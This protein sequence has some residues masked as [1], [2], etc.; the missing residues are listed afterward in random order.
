MKI[1]S[2]IWTLL[3]SFLVAFGLWLYVITVVSPESE[4]TY[5]DIPVTYQNDILEERGL[6]IVSE[7]PVKPPHTK[8]AQAVF[9]DDSN[10]ADKNKRL[11][12][13]SVEFYRLSLDNHSSRSS[14]SGMI[15]PIIMAKISLNAS[16][17]TPPHNNQRCRCL[18]PHKRFQCP[19]FSKPEFYPS[20]CKRC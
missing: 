19:K 15:Q 11:F 20:S 17:I 5:Y 4:E 16:S 18:A 7:K 6:M 3:L 10:A 2:K 13:F 14:S 9:V 1:S 12:R 8:L